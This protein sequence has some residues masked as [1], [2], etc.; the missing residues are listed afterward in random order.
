LREWDALVP[1][2]PGS[3][4]FTRAGDYYTKA[5]GVCLAKEAARQIIEANQ[6][7]EA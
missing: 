5:N 6:T 2:L 3:G 1:K 7:N 4:G